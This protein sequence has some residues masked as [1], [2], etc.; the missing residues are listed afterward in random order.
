MPLATT[1][2]SS[3]APSMCVLR[4]C[5]RATR[6]TS[7]TA[8]SDQTLPPPEFAVFSSETMRVRALWGSGSLM[9]SALG[10]VGVRVAVQQQFV[11]GA[12]M[13]FDGDQVAH[14]AAGQED[15]RLLAEQFRR[16]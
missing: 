10:R 3:R 13:H 7:W 16:H 5:A 12:A 6:A 15:S 11:A 14:R 4:P 9:A 8:S 1:A 2:F